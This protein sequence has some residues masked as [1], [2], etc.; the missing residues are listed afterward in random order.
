MSRVNAKIFGNDIEE[1]KKNQDHLYQ[2]LLEKLP[3]AV[4]TCDK[5]GRITFY[6]KA[7][8]KLWGRE[9]QLN[10]DKWCGSWKTYD[11]DG[12]LLQEDS[13][14]IAVTLR[15]GNTGSMHEL[16]IQRPN[17]S[18]SHVIPHPQPLFDIKG[19]ITGA[20][21]MLVDITPQHETLEA[22]RESEERFR[23][24]ADTAPVMIW[25]ADLEKMCSFFN[26]RW[27]EF[28]GRDLKEELGTG[29][30]TAVHPDDVTR[31]ITIYKTSFDNREEFQKEYRLRRHDK[32]YR[33]VECHGVPRYSCDGTF[34]GYIGTCIDIHEKKLAGKELERKIAESTAELKL[35]NQEL[36]RSN[37]E[38]ASFSYVAS[39]DLQEPLR[40]IIT[41]GDRLILQH[42]KNIPE[43]A[44]VYLE[45]MISSSR[46]MTK[47]VDDILN[48]SHSTKSEEKYQPV[49]LND[50]LKHV[51]HDFDQSI[52]EKKATLK[53][54]SLP[55]IKAVPLQM[56]QLFHNLIS[57][58]LKFARKDIRPEIEISSITLDKNELQLHDVDPRY[59]YCMITVRDNG[60]GFSPQYADTIFKIFQRLHGKSEYSGSGIGLALC[61]K[62]ADN[63][64][65]RI[66]ASSDST[67]TNFFVILPTDLT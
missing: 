13:M 53:I 9:P 46:R 33:W 1:A 18:L 6:N 7:A 61:R 44:M 2:A 3:T 27:T 67:G 20:F 40:K 36:E 30:L 49:N 26:R 31:C 15:E 51:L 52:M 25:M 28:T 62:I 32:T 17:G 19:N 47:L 55:E 12:S 22:L 24:L 45:K 60:I 11:R 10:V 58:S 48:F 59:N 23:N 54:G 38:L 56:T 14:P 57:N 66:F 37:A 35:K 4:Y 41:F 8:S 65:G 63:H 16:I 29:W 39:H 64:H 34:L 21:N 50:T 43:D 5:E 42:G